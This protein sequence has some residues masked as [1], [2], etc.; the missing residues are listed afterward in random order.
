MSICD[1]CAADLQRHGSESQ[2]MRC[3]CN[4]F[5][6]KVS[7][8]DARAA[9]FDAKVSICDACAADLCEYGGKGGPSWGAD[10]TKVSVLP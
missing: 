8:C 9:D 6:A 1:A 2:H 5:E 7:I 4:G 3:L 10:N